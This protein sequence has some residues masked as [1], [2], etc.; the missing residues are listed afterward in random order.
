MSNRDELQGNKTDHDMLITIE[1][2]SRHTKETLEEVR[3]HLRKLNGRVA[4]LE[5]WRAYWTG[6]L[7]VAWIVILILLKEVVFK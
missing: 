6:G 7:A 2:N 3:D 5:N 1:A 4:T